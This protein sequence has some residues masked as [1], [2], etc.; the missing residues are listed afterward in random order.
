MCLKLTNLHTIKNLG[1]MDV[2]TN[3]LPAITCAVSVLGYLGVLYEKRIALDRGQCQLAGNV[4]LRLANL[5]FNVCMIL[6]NVLH[7]KFT[8]EW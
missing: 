3:L 2:R 5:V 7:V 1:K 8:F 6:S 4:S